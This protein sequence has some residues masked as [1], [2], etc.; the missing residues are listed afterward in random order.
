[1]IQQGSTLPRTTTKPPLG[2]GSK[3]RAVPQLHVNPRALSQELTCGVDRGERSPAQLLQGTEA[4][5]LLSPELEPNHP[6][7][8][9]L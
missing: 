4:K 2:F 8:R 3:L 6:L 5:L 9:N 1:M 7:E